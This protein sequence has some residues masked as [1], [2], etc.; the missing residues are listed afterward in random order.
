MHALVDERS[1]ER[2]VN[3]LERP[4]RTGGPEPAIRRRRLLTA[5][6]AGVVTAMIATAGCASPRRT[7]AKKLLESIAKANRRHSIAF[8]QFE[9]IAAA[10]LDEGETATND[11][12]AAGLEKLKAS[13]A[14]LLEESLAWEVPETTEATSLISTY[15]RV[16][17]AR[18]KLMADFE[19]PF[20]ETIRNPVLPQAQRTKKAGQL[21]QSMSI[22]ESSLIMDLRRAQRDY[23]GAMGVFSYE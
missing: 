11:D 20:L 4:A 7:E 13:I 1:R 6:V 21:F 18:Q 23:A 10:R 8:K 17:T 12:V 22:A 19:T 3:P 15:R 2:S 16:V 9:D 14:T 5:G